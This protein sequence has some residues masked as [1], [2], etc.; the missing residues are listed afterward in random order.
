MSE[1]DLPRH[2]SVAEVAEAYGVSTQTVYRWIRA[3]S[4]RAREFDGLIRIPATELDAFGRDVQ[5]ENRYLAYAAT[6]DEESQKHTDE[7]LKVL[8][9][10]LSRSTTASM[11]AVDSTIPFFWADEAARKFMRCQVARLLLS[12]HDVPECASSPAPGTEFVLKRVFLWPKDCWNRDWYRAG[13][14]LHL[15][16]GIEAYHADPAEVSNELG[17]PVEDYEIALFDAE[18]DEHA[19]AVV[20]KK[21]EGRFAAFELVRRSDDSDTV[22]QYRRWFT[23]MIDSGLAHPI[24]W[25]EKRRSVIHGS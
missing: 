17:I 22:D 2:F 9:D 12:R 14:W 11:W 15:V 5:P 3:R 4:L 10:E 7:I 19:R 21:T 20:A 16:L 13:L 6:A 25:D 23:E 1:R 18:S 8:T 24:D